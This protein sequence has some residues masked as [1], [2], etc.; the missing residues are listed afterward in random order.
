MHDNVREFLTSNVALEDFQCST[1]NANRYSLD[2]LRIFLHE[3]VVSILLKN[4]N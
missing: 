2:V 3:A 4:P 1:K